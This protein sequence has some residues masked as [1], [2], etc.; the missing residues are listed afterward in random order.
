MI[1]ILGCLTPVNKE[2]YFESLG[3]HSRLCAGFMLE[4]FSI[5][6][7]FGLQHPNWDLLK[8]SEK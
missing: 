1:F 2:L 4:D 5:S 8:K 6:V 7:F 3:S